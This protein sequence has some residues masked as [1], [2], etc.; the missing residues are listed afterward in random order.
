L[1]LAVTSLLDID[2]LEAPPLYPAL[3]LA[4]SLAGSHDLEYYP[5]TVYY[6]LQTDC[7]LALE[8]SFYYPALKYSELV[9]ADI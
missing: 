5:T 2:A 1:Q 9:G 4:G 8:L 7:S 6:R 3:A